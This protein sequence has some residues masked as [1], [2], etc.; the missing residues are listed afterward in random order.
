MKGPRLLRSTPFAVVLVAA[1]ISALAGCSGAEA[2][3]APAAPEVGV[4]TVA[5]SAIPLVAELPGRVEA[6]RVAEVRARAAGIVLKR[7]F[8]EGSEVKAGDRLFQIDP[9]PLR[10]AQA[11]A[12]ASLSRAQAALNVARLKAERYSSLVETRA[13]SQQEYD[14]AVATRDLAQAD[15]DLAKAALETASLNLGYATVTAPIRGRIGRA[16]VTEGALVG[17]NEATPLATVQQIDPVYVNLTQSS[18][19][20]LRL[21]RALESGSAANGTAQVVILT[22][23]GREHPLPGRL[24]FSEVSVDESTGTIALRAEV[25]NPD[26]S[27]LPGM[28]VRARLQQAVARDAITVPQQ[29]VVRAG[30]AASVWVVKNGKAERREVKVSSAHGDQWVIASGLSAGEHVVVDGL[31][32][33]QPGAD[34]K[35]VAWPGSQV[36]TTAEQTQKN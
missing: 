28:Y 22:E 25:P 35:P 13:I 33:V 12:R 11:S 9:A 29:A 30:D 1:G 17:Q 32:R 7:E 8:E 19:D 3:P 27:L 31:Q 16:A 10:A 15:V 21:K 4:V 20:A 2:P 6:S 5:A 36:A 26:R 18:S 34:V 23:D 24:L 14:D